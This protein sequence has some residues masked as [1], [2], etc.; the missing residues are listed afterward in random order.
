MPSQTKIAPPVFAPGDR[1]V[2][3]KGVASAAQHDSERESVVDV[4]VAAIEKLQK[5]AKPMRGADLG[6]PHDGQSRGD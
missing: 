3:G 2:T 5:P 1:S 6:P 4:V